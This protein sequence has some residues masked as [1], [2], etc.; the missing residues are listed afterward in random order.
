MSVR[1]G[2]VHALTASIPPIEA[3]FTAVWP[4]AQVVNLCD[5][6]LYV[7][8][9]RWG[10]ET[11]EIT[12]RVTALL[13]YSADSGAQG[14]LF[15]GSLFSQSVEAARAK[16]NIPVLTAYEAMIEAAF[17]GSATETRTSI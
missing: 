11:D 2:V 15:S 1:I 7:D 3:A 13:A 10:R 17:S 9:E 5:Q 8:Y 6:S 4:E 12:R 16:M 14:I